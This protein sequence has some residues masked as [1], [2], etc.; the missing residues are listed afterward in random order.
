MNLYDLCVLRGSIK[1]MTEDCRNMVEW[2]RSCFGWRHPT[3][4]ARCMKPLV[5]GALAACLVLACKSR[6]E[7]VRDAAPLDSSDLA[8]D[9]RVKTAGPASEPSIPR[10]WASIRSR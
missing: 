7:R 3:A 10:D 1:R 2:T 6:R 8:R 5:F 9:P 4:A